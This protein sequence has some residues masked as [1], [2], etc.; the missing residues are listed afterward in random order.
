M[1][2][3]LA[4]SGRLNLAE[5][6]NMASEMVHVSGADEGRDGV[7]VEGEQAASDRRKP[8]RAP[9]L[10]VYGSVRELTLGNNGASPDVATKRKKTKPS[11]PRVK[12]NIL[13][14]GTHSLGIGLYLFEY[15]RDFL[16]DRRRHFGVMADEVERVMP[17]AVS[18]DENGIRQVD[19]ALLGIDDFA[20]QLEH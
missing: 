20:R 12:Q 17:E 13:R 14:I 5:G 10:V 2:W 18:R 11:D 7:R 4:L 6:K 9:R 1:R 15:K 19:H 8:Y 3:S 16:D